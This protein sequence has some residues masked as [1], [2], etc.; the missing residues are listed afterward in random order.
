ML[1]LRSQFLLLAILSMFSYC[2]GNTCIGA[3]AIES[4]AQYDKVTKKKSKVKWAIVALTRPGK[5]D[6]QARNQALVEKLKPFA[7]K[8]DVTV[9][10]FSELVFPE[11]FLPRM[12]QLFQ[13]IADVKVINTAD[14]GF[15]MRE[16][17]GYKYMCKFFSL[18]LYDYLK[19]YDYYMR[20]D[21]DCIIKNMQFD[22]FRWAED[23]NLGYGFALRKLEAH[24]PTKQMLPVW[25]TKYS[26]R[27]SIQP[28]AVMDRPLSVCFNFYNNWHMGSVQFFNRPDVRH[29][30][31]NVNASGHI[32]NDRWGDSTIQA[33]AVRLFMNPKQIIQ[34]P[35]FT[36]IHGSHNAMVTTIGDGSDVTVPQKLPNWKYSL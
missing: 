36:Y 2:L 4:I 33:Y 31:E 1:V 5:T 9:I 13:G 20:C 28:S 30:L 35:N 17:Y 7:S 22:I 27:C 29:F 18:D 11:S 12:N 19:G 26:Q 3:D 32:L 15:N 21:T 14:R 10:F 16:R 23:N 6:M 25:V 24:G 8:H 34:V